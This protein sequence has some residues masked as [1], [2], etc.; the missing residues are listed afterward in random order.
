MVCSPYLKGVTVSPLSVDDWLAAAFGILARE[1]AGALTVERLTDALGVTKGSFYHHFASRDDLKLRLL[2]YWEER[3]T[4]DVIAETESTPSP[5]DEPSRLM[6]SLTKRSPDAE[7]AIRAWAL[8]DQD[9]R[10]H[11]A[12][13]DSIRTAQATAWF[14]QSMAEADA[15]VAARTMN[16]LLVGCYSVLPPV[17][18]QELKQIMTQFLLRYV[19]KGG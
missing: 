3:L 17:E 2:G 18:N 6:E 12:R 13:V 1:G 8:E 5:A 9:V 4:S 7:R 11:L 19:R 15:R 16:A 10:A 14:C